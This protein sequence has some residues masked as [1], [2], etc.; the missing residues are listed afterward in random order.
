[1]SITAKII[2]MSKKIQIGPF[3]WTLTRTPPEDDMG[4]TDFESLTISY[5]D[6]PKY[7][8]QQLP[9][10]LLHEILHA[11]LFTTAYRE[12]FNDDE[13]EHLIRSIS[14]L[15]YQALTQV[16]AEM[17]DKAPKKD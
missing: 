8:P 9:E 3:Q 12:F 16:Q 5:T 15:L 13:E 1:M 11:V 17:F 2:I 4:G 7:D 6:D 10:T 14:P